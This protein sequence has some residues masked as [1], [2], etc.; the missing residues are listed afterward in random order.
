MRGRRG[1]QRQVVAKGH[2][3]RCP[4]ADQ[5]VVAKRHVGGAEKD[6]RL[7]R[8]GDDVHRPAGGVLPEQRPL[9]P[10]QHLHPLDVEKVVVQR[11]GRSDVDAVQV[12]GDGR[13]GDGVLVR[14]VADAANGDD[15]LEAFVLGHRDPRQR[16]SEVHERENVA[17]VEIL[18]RRHG[19]G[20][21]QFLQVLGAFL[22]GDDDLDQPRPRGF[23]R[24]G[25]G[26]RRRAC[27][28]EREDD[29][30]GK[31]LPRKTHGKKPRV[32]RPGGRRPQ[33]P[34]TRRGFVEL[35]LNLII[36]EPELHCEPRL[37]SE[38]H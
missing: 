17:G 20:L 3:Q 28:D 22:R 19:D 14:L 21:G 12:I 36:A 26:G 1:A 13:I 34:P 4:G 37:D 7:R 18:R 24:L 25:L 29:G 10:A 32:G 8:G 27:A 35:A 16:R 30:K 38:L 5:V 31:T 6:R 33:A 23:A 11:E 2:V 15:R 9:R